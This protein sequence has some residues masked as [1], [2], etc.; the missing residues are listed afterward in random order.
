[1]PPPTYEVVDE[2]GPPHGK[3]FTL[4]VRVRG[5]TARADGASKKSAEQKAAQLALERLVRQDDSDF[6]E[7]DGGRTNETEG[8]PAS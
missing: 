5:V 6:V 7:N 2:T 1:M 3:T 4:E 8:S